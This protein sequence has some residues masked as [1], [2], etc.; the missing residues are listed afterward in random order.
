M[1]SVGINVTE[2]G[3]LLVFSIVPTAGEYMNIP[4]MLAVAL[5][6]FPESGEPKTTAAGVAQEITGIACV[7]E[8]DPA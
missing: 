6:T 8:S 3:M 4:G 5:N 2:S 1:A 7:T